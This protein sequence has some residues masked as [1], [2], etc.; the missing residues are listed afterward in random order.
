MFA[1]L[2]G[3]EPF[4]ELGYDPLAPPMV[5]DETAAERPSIALVKRSDDLG[6]FLLD[7][8]E[9]ST[10]EP[11]GRFEPLG[12]R[13]QRNK[14]LGVIRRLRK[15]EENM[16]PPLVRRGFARDVGPD[17]WLR[18]LGSSVQ[19]CEQQQVTVPGIKMAQHGLGQHRYPKSLVPRR[20]HEPLARKPMERVPDRGNAG[21][22][23]V[24]EDS[25]LKT[26]ARPEHAFAQLLFDG[27]I[28]SLKRAWPGHRMGPSGRGLERLPV[29]VPDKLGHELRLVRPQR[30]DRSDPLRKFVR[31]KH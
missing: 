10:F 11:L 17:I 16:V 22:E 5:M 1:G 19:Y 8:I 15:R 2:A 7:G 27:S 12:E 13:A 30:V 23:L 31:E 4:E 9:Q 14:V 24:R 29:L 6:R 20:F 28:D 3:V 18:D 21:V 25:R 26:I